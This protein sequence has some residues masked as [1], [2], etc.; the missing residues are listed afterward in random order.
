MQSH[1]LLSY[2]PVYAAHFGQSVSQ[3]SD[4]S[5]DGHIHTKHFAFSIWAPIDHG[6]VDWPIL[7]LW[8]G[9]GDADVGVKGARACVARRADDG[10]P[11]LA[12]E[13]IL[14]ER[15]VALHVT[16]EG[17]RGNVLVWPTGAIL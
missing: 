12:L 5:I 17:L 2:I 16:D 13:E 11:E 10:R 8:E 15:V 9:Q 1:A 4:E 6:D 14:D 3:V 7:A